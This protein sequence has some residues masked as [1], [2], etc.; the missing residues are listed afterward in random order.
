[1]Q[2]G[3]YQVDKYTICAGFVVKGGVVL[4]CAP[5]LQKK[6]TFWTQFARRIACFFP[7]IQRLPD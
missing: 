1:M 2:D 4:V 3:I 7:T 6:F 5:V